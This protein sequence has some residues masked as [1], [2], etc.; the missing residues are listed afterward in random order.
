M[1]D[2]FLPV[3]PEIVL[4]AYMHGIFPM[5][6]SRTDPQ[7]E[8]F[9]P[10]R[11][12]VLPLDGFHQPRRLRRTVKQNRLQ[13]TVDHDFRGTMEACADEAEDRK[14]TWISDR[15][16]ELYTEL[17][18]MG[19]AHSVETRLDGRL[20]GGLY[21]V[22]IG[23]AFFGESMF[24]RVTDASKV[25]LVHLVARLRIGGYALLDCQ[26]QTEHLA[27]FGTV[28]VP[29]LAYRRQLA[30]ALK[31]RGNFHAAPA[32]WPPDAVLDALT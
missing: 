32:D 5:A 29:R 25:A 28:E 31:V 24:S 19:H 30:A 20:V 4:R 12:G 10:I 3:T 9:D 7:L 2:T 22:S 6:H 15:I 16:I 13:V 18:R 27:Q 14:S 23:G 8:W 21:G 11:R 17:N 26:F 1:S